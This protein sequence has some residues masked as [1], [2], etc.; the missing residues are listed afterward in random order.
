PAARRSCDAT[1]PAV[2]RRCRRGPRPLAP[3]YRRCDAGLRQPRAK[4]SRA[5]IYFVSR[6]FWFYLFSLLIVIPGIVSLVLPGGL[7]K[8]IEFSSGTTFTARFNTDVSE[9]DFRGALASLGHPDARVQRSGDGKLLVKTGQLRVA[10][11]A[12]PG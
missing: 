9:Q 4:E 10:G 5:M 6:R 12:P 11:S 7:R 2:R 8:G 1:P 3:R